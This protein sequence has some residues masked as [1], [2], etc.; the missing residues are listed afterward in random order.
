MKHTGLMFPADFPW[1]NVSSQEVMLI[2][3]FSPSSIDFSHR[4][5]VFNQFYQFWNHKPRWC[6][7][8]HYKGGGSGPTFLSGWITEPRNMRK[9]TD[10]VVD[11]SIYLVDISIDGRVYI[12]PPHFCS[13][14]LKLYCFIIEY[15]HWWLTNIQSMVD[16]LE[17]PGLWRIRF[18]SSYIN[19]CCKTFAGIDQTKLSFLSVILFEYLLWWLNQLC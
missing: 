2:H 17:K 18:T 9:R 8:G 12:N 5:S 14:P 4:S 7:P 11:I 6:L 16:I 15:N 3:H 19:M 1:T 10:Y 13:K